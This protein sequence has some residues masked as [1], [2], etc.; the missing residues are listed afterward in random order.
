[1][2][3]YLKDYLLSSASCFP[4][5]PIHE[6]NGHSFID[7]GY[8]D[9]LLIDLAFKM[10]AEEVIAVEITYGR[11]IH[12]HYENRPNITVIRPILYNGQFFDFDKGMLNHRQK[13]GYNDTMKKLG[14]YLGKNYTF[15]PCDEIELAK[16]LYMDI[17][18]YEAKLNA[19]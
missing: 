16:N 1:M 3:G 8:H 4:A 2:K 19:S 10:G 15:Y 12:P 14:G 13:L 6:F 11:I 5:F 18:S 9:N 17:L 7:G